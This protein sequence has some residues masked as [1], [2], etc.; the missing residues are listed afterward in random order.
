MD[1]HGYET[2]FDQTTAW[3]CPLNAEDIAADYGVELAVAL[4]AVD[5]HTVLPAPPPP[6]TLLTDGTPLLDRPDFWAAHL[7]IGHGR[8]DLIAAACGITPAQAR[9]AYTELLHRPD[10]WPV[11]TVP[12]PAGGVIVIAHCLQRLWMLGPDCTWLPDDES[13]TDFWLAAPTGHGV[14]L[15]LISGNWRGP[16][17]RWPEL[18][19]I[20]RAAAP[21]RLAVAQ[22]L[23]LL[24]PILGAAD[25]DDEAADWFAW[26]LALVTNKPAP[27]TVVRVAA[28]YLASG[29]EVFRSARWREIDGVWVSD[30]KFCPRYWAGRQTPSDELRRISDM[31]CATGC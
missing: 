4:R 8:R 24:A 17:L 14:P 3:D 21:D 12:L 23:L 6:V 26:A 5:E 19:T 30:G 2:R 20:A 15:A 10:S 13:W 7:G 29:N 31:L 11:I 25:A 16:G 28:D 27:D 1:L 9:T 22:R 18:R